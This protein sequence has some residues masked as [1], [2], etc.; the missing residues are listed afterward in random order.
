MQGTSSIMHLR[1]TAR[2]GL[3]K[4]LRMAVMSTWLVHTLPLGLHHTRR[5]CTPGRQQQGLVHRQAAIHRRT[6][7]KGVLD[8]TGLGLACIR[9]QRECGLLGRL[10]RVAVCCQCSA[11]R[12]N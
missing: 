5:T 8:L 4:R 10:S 9:L 2:H 7:H 6:R 11:V 3:G 1:T 12:D